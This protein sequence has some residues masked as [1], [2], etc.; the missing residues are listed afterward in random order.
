MDAVRED[1]DVV[2]MRAE[3]SGRWRKIIR[4]GN[5]C[6]ENHNKYFCKKY[7]PVH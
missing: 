5:P 7:Q 2:E 6:R 1:I 4:F 3:D